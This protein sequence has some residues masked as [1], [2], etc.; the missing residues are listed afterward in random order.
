MFKDERVKANDLSKDCAMHQKK[1]VKILSFPSMFCK[2]TR[3][4]CL[5]F[6][7][8]AALFPC[9]C[10]ADIET[11]DFLP[12]DVG[13]TW[14]YRDPTN[15]FEKRTI[16]QVRRLEIAPEFQEKIKA[17]FPGI[18][19]EMA[20]YFFEMQV[21]EGTE[22][23]LAAA[24]RTNLPPKQT[25]FFLKTHRGILRSPAIGG[26]K[27]KEGSEFWLQ[28]FFLLPNPL[29]Q[30]QGWQTYAFENRIDLE[31]LGR[32]KVTV[33]LGTYPDCLK[34]SYRFGLEKDAWGEIDFCS[35]MGE[36]RVKEGDF[37][38]ELVQ[39][40]P[41][42]KSAEGATILSPSLTEFFWTFLP[43]DKKISP[44]LKNLNQGARTRRTYGGLSLLAWAFLIPVFFVIVWLLLV[45]GKKWINRPKAKHALDPEK[46][47]GILEESRWLYEQGKMP[48]AEVKLLHLLVH[49]TEDRNL[50]GRAF[51]QLGLVCESQGKTREAIENFEEVL[52]IEPK[53][54]EVRL[55]L[56]NLLRG[57]NDLFAS[58][59]HL[60]VFLKI[61]PEDADI[62][63]V[64]GQ[65]LRDIGNIEKAREH[66]E[67]ALALNPH[68]HEA[69]ENIKALTPT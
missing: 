31:F 15:R 9:P 36:V 1:S 65:V 7:M 10:F 11:G 25:F 34:I 17:K 62:H 14:L 46:F 32:E 66:F 24:A 6:L 18:T 42:K 48:E 51:F 41:G 52:E 59:E 38:R 39:F 54:P 26:E 53:N 12:L 43:Q 29:A 21:W 56:A 35:G 45:S 69:R 55:K 58:Y 16:K 67:K 5:G 57:K 3:Y 4:F 27:G 50:Q 33:P 40:T 61:K 23:E 28:A 20:L 64:C 37:V 68:F 2:L 30:E 13:T 8:L 63:N 47:Q 19:E 49:H 44:D 22:S 60:R